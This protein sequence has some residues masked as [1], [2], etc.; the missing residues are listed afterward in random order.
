[1]RCWW[2]SVD[3]CNNWLLN[4][5]HCLQASLHSVLKSQKRRTT[6]SWTGRNTSSSP[7]SYHPSHHKLNSSYAG[8]DY[9]CICHGSCDPLCC[10]HSFLCDPTERIGQKV[11]DIKFHSF[12]RG[13]DWDHIR[14]ALIKV[15]ESLLIYIM[16][17]GST[18]CYSSQCKINSGYIKLWWFPWDWKKWWVMWSSL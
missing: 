12:F 6:K 14:W 11:E 1:M 9:Y 7:Q 13:I 17:Q 8:M 5:W 18:S 3:S 4:V 16:P 2:V 15:S 10:S